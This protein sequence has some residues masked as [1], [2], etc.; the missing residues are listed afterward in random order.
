MHASITHMLFQFKFRTLW[1]H[2]GF[3]KTCKFITQCIPNL[4]SASISV[5]TWTD[6]VPYLISHPRNPGWAGAIN[7]LPVKDQF[8]IFLEVMCVWRKPLRNSPKDVQLRQLKNDVRACLS[9]ML[10]PK[11]LDSWI[12]RT[13]GWSGSSLRPSQAGVSMKG[14]LVEVED[15]HKASRGGSFRYIVHSDC[16]TPHETMTV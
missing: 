7:N 10:M 15:T 5:I 8:H 11:S 12:L 9:A 4:L 1:Y 2:T 16:L 3:T 14:W 13:S 6:I